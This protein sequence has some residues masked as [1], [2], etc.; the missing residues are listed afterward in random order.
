MDRTITLQKTKLRCPFCDSETVREFT[1]EICSTCGTVMKEWKQCKCCGEYTIPENVCADFCAGCR[2][3]VK[4]KLYKFLKENFN[5][6]ELE[7]LDEEV[8]TSFY[9]FLKDYE[10]ANG[11]E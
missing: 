8:D 2:K 3:K 9:W 5:E 10:E 1:Y 7:V 11:G 6:T 4:D